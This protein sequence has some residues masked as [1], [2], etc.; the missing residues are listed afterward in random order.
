[1]VSVDHMTKVIVFSSSGLRTPGISCEITVYAHLPSEL[2][3]F[4][5]LTIVISAMQ[6][7]SADRLLAVLVPRPT[8]PF[9]PQGSANE[10]QLQPGRQRRVYSFY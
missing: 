5:Q 1:V 8:L 3:W 6:P 2:C 9:I 4:E 10:D 7:S